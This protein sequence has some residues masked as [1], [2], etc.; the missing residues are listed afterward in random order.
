MLSW[1]IDRIF[2]ALTL[3][4]ISCG[5]NSLADSGP[6]ETEPTNDGACGEV[7]THDVTVTAR[8]TFEDTPME[9]V[10]VELL[11]R[12]WTPGDILASGLTD[13]F[14]SITLDI[15]GLTA[16]EDCWGTMLD[17]YLTASVDDSS[18]AL[19]G[20]KQMNSHLQSAINNG[21]LTVDVSSFP[22]ELE[23]GR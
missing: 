11:D 19:Y 1:S 21:S 20:E 15:V 2:P 17:Y 12:G 6:T 9:G 7:S 4:A 23:A 8:V 10:T 3:V 18:G 5:G 16:V 13:E 22:I 14:G